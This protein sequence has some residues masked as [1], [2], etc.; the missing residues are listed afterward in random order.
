MIKA[1]EFPNRTFSTKEDLFKELL[2]HQELIIERKKA[3]IWKS[4]E[5][6]QMSVLAIEDLD[7]SKGISGAKAD[8]IYPIIS[9]TRYKDSH[10]DVHFDGC[11]GKTVKDQ[12]GKV[13]YALDHELKWDSIIAW[14]ED[15]RMFVKKIDWALVGKEYEGQTEALVFEIHKDKFKRKDVLEAIV[16]KNHDFENS[17]RMQYVKITLGINSTSPEYKAQKSYYDSRIEEIANKDVAEADGY[18]WGVEELRIQKEGSLVVAGGSNDAT[19]IYQK[20]NTEPL[21]DTH[22]NKEGSRSSTISFSEIKFL[23]N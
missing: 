7:V 18:F 2:K 23:N 9:T 5:K 15:V 10:G 3:C 4:C 19:S 1:I 14:K 20:E 6:G 16:S 13:H 22:K 17:I 21:E 11:F 12:Q 8:F